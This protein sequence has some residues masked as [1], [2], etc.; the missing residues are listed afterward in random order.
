[1]QHLHYNSYNTLLTIQYLDKLR[2]KCLVFTLKK[3]PSVC[4][5]VK[6]CAE[7]TTLVWSK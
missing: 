2:W 4:L 1:M 3:K 5:F 7:S 6:S